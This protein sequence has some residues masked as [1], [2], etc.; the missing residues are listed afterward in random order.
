MESN[1]PVA[2]R[3]PRVRQAESRKSRLQTR[4]MTVGAVAL[5]GALGTLARVELSRVLPPSAGI[6]WGTLAANVT[7]SFLLALFAA[8]LLTRRR[9]SRYLAPLFVTGACG[10]FTTLSTFAVDVDLLIRQGDAAKAVLYA[11]ASLA[12]AIAALTAGA[13]TAR[14][15]G[16][17]G[18]DADQATSD[19]ALI[20]EELH[21]PALQ[22]SALEDS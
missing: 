18:D 13:S 9:P 1:E 19:L 4:L 10:S 6:P 7:G 20:S 15:L 14:L 16:A 21:Q 3:P 17:T 5:G 8:S 22:P 2:N 11:V 12:L